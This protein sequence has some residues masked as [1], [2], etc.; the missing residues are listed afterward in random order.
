MTGQ[1]QYDQPVWN[2]KMVYYTALKLDGTTAITSELFE[3]Y[4]LFKDLTTITVP[5]LTSTGKSALGVTATRCEDD[6][7]GDNRPYFAGIITNV[8][9][10]TTGAAWVWVISAG[11]AVPCLVGNTTG[12]DPVTYLGGITNQWYLGTIAGSVASGAA[13]HLSVF[14]VVAKPL[15]VETIASGGVATNVLCDVGPGGIG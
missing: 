14:A 7:D 12:V 5:N 4:A 9:P 8:K 15:K 1:V 3:G 2:Q 11:D 10:G 6:S 13:M